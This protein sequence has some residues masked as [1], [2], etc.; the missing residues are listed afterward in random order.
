M[1][2]WTSEMWQAMAIG[3]IIGLILGYL[4]MRFTKDSVKKQIQTETELQKVKTQLDTQKEQLEKHFAE[5]AELLKDL[6]QDYQKLYQHLAK[7]SSTL[8]P[9]QQQATLFA[10][11]LLEVEKQQ[12]ES[13]VENLEAQPRDYSE[14][15][16]GL[17][18]EK[19]SK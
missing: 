8:L 2:N 11:P 12:D 5:S 19:P 9:D 18:K 14:K 4:L 17:L 3:L 10:Q 1:E 13:L 15:P 7:S 16:S 6:A